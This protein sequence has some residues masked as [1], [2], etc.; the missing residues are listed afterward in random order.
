MRKSVGNCGAGEIG[1]AATPQPQPVSGDTEMVVRR[2]RFSEKDLFEALNLNY[3]GLEEVAAAYKRGDLSTSKRALAA[4]F[5]RR[6]E[7]HWYFPAGEKT[8]PRPGNPDLE[9]ANRALRHE[10]VSIGIHHVFGPVVDWNFDV[11]TAPGS[12]YPA[13]NEWTWQLNRHSEWVALARAYSAT[14]DEKYAREWV[15]QMVRWVR[16]S[17][18]PAGSG[19]LPRSSWR[20]IESGIR[21]GGPWPE[22]FHRF[23]LSPEFTDDALL[24]MVQSFGD[25][26][27]HL[28]AHPST[29]NWLT[30]EANGL[31]HVGVLFPEFKA[32]SQW[33]AEAMKWLYRELNAQ[34][35]PDGVQIE[36]Y[37][38]YHDVSRRSFLG[39]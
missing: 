6:K 30:M 20:T 33:R 9:A 38:S 7:P 15:S 18:V 29:G 34:V 8:K 11:T 35:Y 26:A 1:A 31:Y 5:R 14:S 3:K 32:A 4:Y 22:I 2:A 12:Q 37:S 13:N 36:L 25:H 28:I 19:N 39:A 27:R 17:P 10:M 24:T 21:A 16:D 23:L